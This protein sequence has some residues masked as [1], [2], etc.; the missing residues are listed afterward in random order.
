MRFRSE[1]IAVRDLSAGAPVGYGHSFC[2]ERAS[3]IA[4][5]PVG[6]D[7]GYLRSLSN[8]ASVL[9]RGE[10]CPVVGRV[11]MKALMVDVSDVDGVAIGDEAILL[12][13]QG[14]EI[15]TIE[16]LAGWGGTISYELLCLLGRRNQR[17]F[18]GGES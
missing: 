17:S 8:R 14:D 2:T 12:G 1:V 18:R 11:C 15:I 4:V 10:R 16:E 5:L 9:V 3:R 13:E 7:D 6:Y